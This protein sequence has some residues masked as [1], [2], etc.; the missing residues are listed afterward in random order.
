MAKTP[1]FIGFVDDA[2]HF[3]LDRREDF[4]KAL[5]PFK[6]QEVVLTVEARGRSR[7][8]AQNRWLWGCALPL[9]A[10]HCGYDHHEH[11]RLHYDLLSV[12]FGTVAIAP[13][14]PQAPPRIVPSKTSSELNT[15]EFSEYM[16]W[17]VRYAAETFSVVIPLPD[18]ADP[19]P[20]P[21]RTGARA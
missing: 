13:L 15:K 2:G 12:R 5:E 7:S 10:D 1:G 3:T 6:G 21:A 16:D 19:D 20:A 11:E 17:L 8:A 14:V 4:L 9:I 18:E